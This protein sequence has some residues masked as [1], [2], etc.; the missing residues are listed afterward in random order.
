MYKKACIEHRPAAGVG[1]RIGDR[2]DPVGLRG[3]SRRPGAVGYWPATA[4]VSISH[5]LRV[6]HAQPAEPGNIHGGLSYYCTTVTAVRGG[7][8]GP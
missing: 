3:Q 4:C 5:H 2:A 8:A 1:Q 7:M 6:A